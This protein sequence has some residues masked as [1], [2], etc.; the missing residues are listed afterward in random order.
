M[1]AAIEQPGVEI[2]RREIG[3]HVGE[4][5]GP[6]LI[7]VAGIHGNEP[8]GIEAARRVF[9]RLSKGDLRFRGEFAAFAGNVAAL[10]RGVRYQARDLN[11]AWSEERVAALRTLPV[12]ERGPE[13][14]EQAE[15][16][17]AI[18]A[19]IGRARGPVHLGDLHTTSAAGIP[20]IL[21][22]DTLAQRRFARAF[23]LPIILGLEEQIDGVLTEYWT[24]RGCTTFAIEG[25][26]NQSPDSIDA[27]EAVLWLALAR[28][29]HL[30]GAAPEVARS[31]ALLDQRRAGLPRV[32]E[33]ISRRSVSPQDSFR[34]EPGFR[35]I[36]RARKGQLLA[37]DRSGEIRARKDGMVILP[38]YQGLG[39]DGFFWGR[40]ASGARLLAS[41]ALRS[42]GADRLLGLLPGVR[43]DAENPSRFVVDAQS[44][45]S[46]AIEVF[47]LLGY[48]RVRQQ[49]A[50]LIIERQ[51]V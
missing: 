5:P 31:A 18:E 17:A 15:L 35:N 11:R 36:D 33:V 24:R 38:L 20:F 4:R 37:R 48:R 50:E 27:I 6:S 10:R 12:G 13:D 1:E 25:G 44:A 7:A 34:M 42:I 39:G 19:A 32:V 49:G 21:F 3:R 47:H 14:H 45:R 40:E 16:L 22:G 2:E 51:G 43:R 30:E 28:A 23:P 8:A 9:A 26:Q 41:E 46:L 29:R